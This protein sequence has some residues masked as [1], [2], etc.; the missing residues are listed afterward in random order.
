LASISLKNCIIKARISPSIEKAPTPLRA[1]IL[2]LIFIFRTH[3]AN[4]GAKAG[5]R[6]SS[7]ASMDDG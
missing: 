4:A 7:G 5:S 1:D 6:W 2:F 3:E